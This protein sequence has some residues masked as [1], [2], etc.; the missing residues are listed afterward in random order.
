LKFHFC[1][2]KLRRTWNGGK[3]SNARE[4]CIG[5]GARA[6]AIPIRLMERQFGARKKGFNQKR[7][8]VEILQKRAAETKG[9]H[10]SAG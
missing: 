2:R 7:G 8:G 3:R 4:F 5:G 10:S 9:C 6:Q 1:Y